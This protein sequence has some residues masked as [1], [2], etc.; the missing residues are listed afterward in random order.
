MLL[1]HFLAGAVCRFLLLSYPHTQYKRKKEANSLFHYFLLN[2]V[3]AVL[4]ASLPGS[5]GRVRLADYRHNR[6]I[7]TLSSSERCPLPQD[8]NQKFEKH[9]FKTKMGTNIYFKNVTVVTS[10]RILLLQQPKL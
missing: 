1:P 9:L 7:F 8:N 5:T 4:C 2:G 3:N 10:V 6:K